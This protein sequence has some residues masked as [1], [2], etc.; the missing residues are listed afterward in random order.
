[1]NKTSLSPKKTSISQNMPAK[2]AKFGLKN[3]KH[4]AEV[5]S[6]PLKGSNK[7]SKTRTSHG[8]KTKIHNNMGEQMNLLQK[9]GKQTLKRGII[10][11]DCEE[12]NKINKYFPT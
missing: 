5:M 6:K 10:H 12:A 8:G 9:K 1:M 11:D 2:Q 4:T 7:V 3:R